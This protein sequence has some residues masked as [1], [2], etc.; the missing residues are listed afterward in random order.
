GLTSVNR[1]QT[2]I[3]KFALFGEPVS[4]AAARED[5]FT[6]RPWAEVLV[7][8]ILAVLPPILVSGLVQFLLFILLTIPL[9]L[10]A[11]VVGIVRVIYYLFRRR[12]RAATS[13]VLAAGG[14][15]LATFWSITFSDEL[16]WHLLRPSIV[17]VLNDAPA[18][19]AGIRKI[20]WNSGAD[21]VLEYHETD[22][23]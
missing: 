9:I 3:A 20:W 13:T 17:A 21:V 2:T 14:F 15:V 8:W 11:P 22:V 12:W 4:P 18:N 7:I 5:S 10:T 1:A 16:K 19:S 6:P 23:D